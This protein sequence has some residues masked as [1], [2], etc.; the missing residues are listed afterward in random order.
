MTITW[1][2]DPKHRLVT[3]D[4]QTGTLYRVAESRGNW[5]LAVYLQ[6]DRKSCDR[7]LLESMEAAI[8]LAEARIRHDAELVNLARFTKASAVRTPW[9]RARSVTVYAEGVDLLSTADRDGF[10]LSQAINEAIPDHL[11]LDDGWYDEDEAGFRVI[12]ALPECFTGLEVAQAEKAL[13]D[14]D[15][16][17]HETHFNSPNRLGL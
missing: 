12:L 5:Q 2:S 4:P 16:D 8:E 9:G 3:I 11:R 15:P 7:H 1:T 14:L 17:L 10:R 13:L 6:G